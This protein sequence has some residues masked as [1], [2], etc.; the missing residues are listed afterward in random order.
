MKRDVQAATLFASMATDAARADAGLHTERQERTDS[1]ESTDRTLELHKARG[2]ASAAETT[3]LYARVIK[4]L[5]RNA[6]AGE[7]GPLD[8]ADAT[9]LW[10]GLLAQRFTPAQEAALLMGLRVHGEGPAILAAFARATV[11]HDAAAGVSDAWPRNVVVLHCL[12]SARREPVLAP[13]LA[14]RLAARGVA[15][16][17]VTHDAQRGANAAQVMARLTHRAAVTRAQVRQQLVSGQLA[18]WPIEQAAPAL[19]RLLALRAELGFRNSAHAAIKLWSPL[20]APVRSIIVANYTHAP[21][22]ESFAAAV[23]HA[24]GSALLIRGTEGDPV[25]WT[26]DAHPPLAW[27]DGVEQPLAAAQSLAHG[28][29]PLPAAHD[30]DATVNFTCR[31]LRGHLPVPAAIETQ[32]ELL[33]ALIGSRR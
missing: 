28:D 14:H 8:G 4:R 3:A 2:N 29:A 15:T 12:G 32:A 17:V 16:L 11:E 21:Y 22:R 25:A 13:L 5:G 7:H 18:W 6:R 20:P 10:H 27:I 26:T 31:A 23:E 30:L 33:A 19:A 24:R 1:A 9:A